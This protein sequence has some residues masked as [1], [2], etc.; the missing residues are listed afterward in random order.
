M[1]HC[2][3]RS[4][5]F[6]GRGANGFTLIELTIVVVLLGLLAAVAIPRF[7]DVTEQAE[8]AT[9]EG[10]SGGFATGV[11]LVRAEWELEA[12]PRENQGTNLTFVTIDG[13]IVGVDKDTGY[14]TGQLNNDNSTE[15]DTMSALDCESIFN[16]IM[17]SAP[18][19]TSNWANRPFDSV[20][21]FTNFSN[22]TGSG[23]NDL[24]YYYLSKSVRNLQNPPTDN[25]VGDGFIYDPRIGQVVV[26]SN[27]TSNS[28]N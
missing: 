20:R 22:G 15:D 7:L 1:T 21:Y 23:G 25:T 17:Q 14:P 24:C 8:D 10:V 6:G 4:A 18:S 12:R 16:L 26:F 27:N 11:G 3:Q 19:I 5:G 13:I 28:S 2:K 9:I